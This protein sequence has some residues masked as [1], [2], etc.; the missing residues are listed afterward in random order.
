MSSWALNNSI[1]LL[2]PNKRAFLLYTAFQCKIMN[3][4]NCHN[5]RSMVLAFH[6]LFTL[7]HFLNFIFYLNYHISF[8][9]I[10]LKHDISY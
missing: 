9:T 7:W 8:H 1:W 3:L 6:K 10:Q 4:S 2:N 5:L